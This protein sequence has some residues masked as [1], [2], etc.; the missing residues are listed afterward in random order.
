VATLA[1]VLHVMLLGVWLGASLLF[2]A[3]ASSILAI[4]GSRHMA[5]DVLT[6]A[7]SL[8]DLFGVCASPVLL[9]TLF[10]GWGPLAVPLERR[11]LGAL[12]MAGAVLASRYLVTPRIEA[13]K[14]EMSVRLE[15][16]DPGHPSMHAYDSLHTMS[17]A[18]MILH[19]AAC[20]LM[21]IAA[22][23]TARPKRS[24]GIEL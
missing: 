3:Q 2:V 13:L 10:V 23:R 21:L 16:M 6:A 8:I 17:S 14:A 7:L 4:V 9:V 5:G 15:H 20:F 19:V 12:V 1:R 22:V 11:A 18:L 24:F